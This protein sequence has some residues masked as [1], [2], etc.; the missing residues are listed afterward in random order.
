MKK[1]LLS[2]NA[3]RFV[4]IDDEDF[5]PLSK[6]KW[7]FNGRYAMREGNLAGQSK[8]IY[9]HRFIMN[10]P[11]GMYTDHID[12]NPL[13]NQK[14]N[15]RICTNSQN[16]FNKIKQKNNTSG[17]KGIDWVK[18]DKVWRIRLN[19]N[20]KTVF[21]AYSKNLTEA[22]KIYN[23]AVREHHGTYGRLNEL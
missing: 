5:E 8:T 10:T 16:N 22:V 4:L 20:K 17:Y 11:K 15:L 3:E 9:M 21:L 12:M 23:Q 2:G 19:K 13:N 7:Y 14:S 18:K 6:W 1:L